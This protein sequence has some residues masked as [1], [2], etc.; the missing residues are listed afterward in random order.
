MADTKPT[1]SQAAL[2][3]WLKEGLESGRFQAVPVEDEAGQILRVRLVVYGDGQPVNLQAHDP[4]R[5]QPGR[6]RKQRPL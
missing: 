3:A 5:Q 6:Y 1:D 4:R 2:I